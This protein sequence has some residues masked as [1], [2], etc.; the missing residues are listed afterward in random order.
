MG[1]GGD[2]VNLHILDC[3]HRILV[4]FRNTVTHV[5]MHTRVCMSTCAIML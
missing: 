1:G 3:E 2:T 5:L 4:T